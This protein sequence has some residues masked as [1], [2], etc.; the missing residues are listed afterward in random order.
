MP[1]VGGNGHPLGVEPRV[2]LASQ[3][4]VRRPSCAMFSYFIVYLPSHD[5]RLSWRPS[6]LAWFSFAYASALHGGAGLSAWRKRI[7]RSSM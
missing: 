5:V 6:L 1:L 7:F 4:F 3:V 2:G